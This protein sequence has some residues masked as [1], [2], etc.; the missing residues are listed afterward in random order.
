MRMARKYDLKHLILCFLIEMLFNLFK[1]DFKDYIFGGE[2]L[3]K[4]NYR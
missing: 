4:N 3:L 2:T 1:T